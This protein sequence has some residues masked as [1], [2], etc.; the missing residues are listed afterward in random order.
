MLEIREPED[1]IHAAEE[2]GPPKQSD[3]FTVDEAVEYL[4]FG[5]F[6]WTLSLLTG[7]AWMSD[8]MEMMILSVS[9]QEGRARQKQSAGN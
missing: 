4:G 8:A 2:G 6:Q 9:V 7:L 1:A 5:K 3:S